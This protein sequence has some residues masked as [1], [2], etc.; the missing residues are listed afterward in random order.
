MNSEEKKNYLLLER[1]PIIQ[2]GLEHKWKLVDYVSEYWS[3]SL[4]DQGS[5]S[6]N[7]TLTHIMVVIFLS[8]IFKQLNKNYL[9]H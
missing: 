8:K 6:Q 5:G 4:H 2:I 3:K 7:I 1:E 9:D